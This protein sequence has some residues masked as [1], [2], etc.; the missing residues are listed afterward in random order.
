[1]NIIS[2]T[3]CFL[4]YESCTNIKCNFCA[5]CHVKNLKQNNSLLITVY[6]TKNT[7]VYSGS[8]E[9]TAAFHIALIYVCSP[10]DFFLILPDTALSRW[11]QST[12]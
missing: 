1:M 4:R 9:Y 8:P 7:A 3:N 12:G 10:A 2:F 11:S 6:I 5:H